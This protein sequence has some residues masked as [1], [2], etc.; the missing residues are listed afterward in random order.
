[1]VWSLPHGRRVIAWLAA[2]MM[3]PLSA[4]GADSP[5]ITPDAGSMASADWLTYWTAGTKSYAFDRKSVQQQPGKLEL[6]LRLENKDSKSLNLARIAVDCAADTFTLLSEQ[7]EQGGRFVPLK[8]SV[9]KPLPVGSG[10]MRPL[11]NELCVAWAEPDGVMWERLGQ[12]VDNPKLYVDRAVER[13]MPSGGETGVFKAQVK[14]VAGDLYRTYQTRIDCRNSTQEFLGGL[15]R[16]NYTVKLPPE[17]AAP[18]A[19][20]SAEN[21][22]KHRYCRDEIA[23]RQRVQEV[24]RRAQ[25]EREESDQRSKEA[26]CN[27]ISEKAVV[28]INQFTRMME[29]MDTPPRCID[30]RLDLMNLHSLGRDANHAGC[31]NGYTMFSVADKTGS[32][33]R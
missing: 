13:N 17:A 28:I 26:Y 9:G 6:L 18:I 33:C 3:L 5:S 20:N 14:I 22:L 30:I 31:T 10:F 24:Q 21:I 11:R 16:H 19:T 15:E 25:I 8:T 29:N 12:S 1:M 32:W 2:S 27:Q 23:K 4:A 7:V